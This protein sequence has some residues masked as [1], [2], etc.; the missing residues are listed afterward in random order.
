MIAGRPVAAGTQT[1]APSQAADSTS[2][3]AKSR[4]FGWFL[5]LSLFAYACL[6]AL[7]GLRATAPGHS[8]I[9]VWASTASWVIAAGS[10]VLA[11][12]GLWGFPGLAARWRGLAATGC[13]ASL[14]FL[15]ATM[16]WMMWPMILVDAAILSIAIDSK[17]LELPEKRRGVLKRFGFFLGRL[18]ALILFV[19][20]A[21]TISLRPWYSQWGATDAEIAK[22][23]PDDPVNRSYLIN[24]AVDVKAPP[25]KVWSW[26]IQ[27]GQNKA[28]F[29]SY[30]FL[31]RAIGA[32]IHNVSEIRPEWQHLEAGDFVR[33]CQRDWMGGRWADEAGW[34]VAAVDPGKSFVLQ[35]WGTF[36]VEPSPNGGSRLGVR[37][38]VGEIPFWAAPIELFAFEPAHFIMEQRML[39]TIKE[40]AERGR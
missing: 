31:E 8:E 9:A 23:W 7:P 12:Y 2:S 26:M 36:W 3:K 5:A 21:A 33:A 16:Q 10:F 1:P 14:V 32:D 24:H 17:P 34:H 20:G 18:V 25:E 4:V 28:G 22:V 15:V 11:A 38:K 40:L 37:T 27:L 29:Y 30:D 19:Y 13:L 35:N 39:R 6:H